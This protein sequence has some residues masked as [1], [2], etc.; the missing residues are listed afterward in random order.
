MIGNRVQG[1]FRITESYQAKF[2]TTV[3]VHTPCVRWTSQTSPET[4]SIRG[5]KAIVVVAMKKVSMHN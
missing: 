2:F 5:N 1:K 3:P 4:A